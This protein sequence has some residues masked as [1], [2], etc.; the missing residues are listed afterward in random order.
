MRS[1]EASRTVAGRVGR[2]RLLLPF[3]ARSPSVPYV[4]RRSAPAAAAAAAVAAFNTYRRSLLI[5][6]TR[7]PASRQYALSLSL[8]YNETRHDAVE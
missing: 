2:H 8:H 7:P 3:L 6:T 5:I 4:R 1:P